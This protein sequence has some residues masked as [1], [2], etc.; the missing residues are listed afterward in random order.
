MLDTQSL[1][2]PV[3]QDAPGGKDLEYSAEYDALARALQGRP[4]RKMGDVVVAAEPPDWKSAVEHATSLLRSSKDLR[5][6]TGLTRALLQRDFFAGLA[7]GIALVRALVETLWPVLYPRLEEEE[8]DATAR[9]NAMAALTH[10]EMINAVRAAPLVRSS[11]VGAVSLRDVEAAAARARDGSG[12]P[13]SW[14]AA[15]QPVPLSELT[16]AAR[17][18][19]SCDREARELEVAWKMQLETGGYENGYTGGTRSDDFTALRQV[20][21]QANRF[22]KERL[23]A[24][25]RGEHAGVGGVGNGNG[26]SDGLQATGQ[27]APAAVAG[28]IRSRDD[29]LHALDA[30]CAYYAR[31]EP[32]SPVPLLLERCKRLVAMSFLDIVKDM[33]PDGMQTIETIAGKRNE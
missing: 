1:L 21:V 2:Q 5:V 25:Q 15:F 16:E 32:S 29:V 24:R 23:D 19:E 31:H 3:S 7:Q 13:P 8:K 14:D 6:A 4:E 33:M 26:S 30:I 20:L 12:P 11:A 27:S 28:S 10:R 22:M 18:V 17:D 9:I